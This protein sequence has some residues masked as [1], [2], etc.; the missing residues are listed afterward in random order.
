[1]LLLNPQLPNCTVAPFL[2][3]PFPANARQS[4]QMSNHRADIEYLSRKVVASQAITSPAL[5]VFQSN[6]TPNPLKITLCHSSSKVQLPKPSLIPPSPK[7]RRLS[8]AITD[9][10]AGEIKLHQTAVAL[11][12]ICQGLAVLVPSKAHKQ[13]EANLRNSSWQTNT[14]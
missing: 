9:V 1:M 6:F 8:S 7:H 14:K 5:C 13:M 3:K 10:V 2:T 11:K 12:A 4:Y